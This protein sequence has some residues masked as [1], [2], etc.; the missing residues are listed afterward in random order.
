MLTGQ[1]TIQ[2][3]G[4]GP[5]FVFFFNKT[6]LA[7]GEGLFSGR[8]KTF[9][10]KK[11]TFSPF[12]IKIPNVIIVWEQKLILHQLKHTNPQFYLHDVAARWR[13]LANTISTLPCPCF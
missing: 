11:Y 2:I 9:L 6:A 4:F 8:F 12:Y 5:K 1:E 10:G 3:G 7:D 13:A